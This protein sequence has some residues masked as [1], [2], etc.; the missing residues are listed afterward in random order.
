LGFWIL[1]Q[2]FSGTASLGVETG[3]TAG[4]AWWA[5]IGGFIFGV[6]AGFY[7]RKFKQADPPLIVQNPWT[8]RPVSKMPTTFR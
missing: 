6:A 7:F 2:L 4:V 5:H 8:P 1:Q 3:D